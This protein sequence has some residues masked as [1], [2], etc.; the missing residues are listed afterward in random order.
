MEK[1][2]YYVS[3][4][5][6]NDYWGISPV[7]NDNSFNGPIPP[8]FN[9][10]KDLIAEDINSGKNFEYEF[11]FRG[12]TY[13]FNSPVVVMPHNSAK[14]T[15]KPYENEEVVF[16]GGRMISGFKEEV[17]NGI[18]MFTTDI[19][20]VKT[21]EYEFKELYVNKRF[22][23]KPIFPQNGYLRIVSTPGNPLEGD[24]A[25]GMSVFEAKKEDLDKIENLE[26]AEVIVT[27]YWIEERMPVVRVDRENNYI[28]CDRKSGFQLRDDVNNEFAKYKIENVFEALKNPG[29]WYLDKKTGKLYYIPLE[30]ETVD[31]ILV[32]APLAK[33][34][35]EFWGES[36][37]TVSDISFENIVFENTQSYS[38]GKMP[39]RIAH[40]FYDTE[41]KYA[42]ACQAAVNIHGAI[43]LNGCKGIT[44]EKCTFRNIGN[45]AI[46]I[47]DSCRNNIVNDCK[48]YN[49]GAGAVRIDGGDAFE[50]EKLSTGFNHITNNKI[51]DCTKIFYSAIGI[52]VK[53]GFSNYIAH[54]EIY[55]LKYSGISCGWVWGYT[56]SRAC[57]NVIEYNH[58]HHL[59]DG[60][61][62]DMGGIYML[63]PQGGS[64]IRG[65]V[66]HDIKRANYGG[67]G[68]YLDE[69]SSNIVVE[70]NLVYNT[71]S[72]AMVIHFGKENIVRYNIFSYGKESTVRVVRT[73]RVNTATFYQNIFIHNGI[74]ISGGD[75]SRFE[76][77]MVIF[78][79][80]YYCS[81]N[82]KE[83]MVIC[84]DMNKIPDKQHSWQEW[85]EMG[86]D[87]NSHFVSDIFE[88]NSFKLKQDSAVF[89]FGYR[90]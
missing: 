59:G 19:L 51:Y 63:G 65:N 27:H 14:V 88:D 3:K 49:C 22:A 89:K 58:I 46:Q 85:N 28:Y 41:V 64:E 74:P 13:Y 90:Q 47:G 32:E 31:N 57:S 72:E 16:S 45:Y 34:L 30:G 81:A 39:K 60:N 43:I 2:I 56:K 1:K 26:G 61:M 7:Q 73:M 82:G 38:S 23:E 53:N 10:F 86:Y 36:D 54:N 70:K 77:N 12:G 29:E 67:W 37:K 20:D 76:N 50:D 68:I 24:W 4:E 84:G 62:S 71:D 18:K 44:F 15:F 17:I 79:C 55:N 8:N 75:T 25:K 11:I 21:G 9:Y 6:K 52:F 35:F 33:S 42:A 40:M 69:G 83:P 66:I 48:F 87:L 5:G 78:D 80:N